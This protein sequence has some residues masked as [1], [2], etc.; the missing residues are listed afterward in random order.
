[1]ATAIRQDEANAS[2]F[3]S[4]LPVR[5]KLD[6]A[7]TELLDL[8]ARNRL[9]N[10][11][12]GAKSA[13]SVAIVDERSAEIFR[14]LARDGRPFTFVPGRETGGE[15][16]PEEGTGEIAELAQPQADERGVAARHADTKLQTRLTLT[17]LQKR[18]LEMYFDARTLEEEQGVNIFYLAL[19]ALKWI[20]PQN[21]ANIRHAPLVLVPVALDRGNAAE[22]FKLRARQEEFAANLSLE[23]FLERVHGITLPAFEASDTF[24]PE[25]YIAEVAEA[26][27]EKP[28]DREY[29]RF[30][31]RRRQASVVRRRKDGG[32]RC[33]QAPPRCDRRR[34]RLPRTPQ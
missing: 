14:M 6:R 32:T 2:V 17:G 23:A 7:R 25:T 26:V 27:R 21:A 10:M 20:D 4:N 13:K 8:S 29:S 12:R 3:Q 5:E 24:D 22:K 9:L 30:G 19:G 34:R 33:G 11:P 16:Q 18:L 1:M 28:D 15:D 31:D